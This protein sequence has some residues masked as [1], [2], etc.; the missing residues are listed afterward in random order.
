L[1]AEATASTET[2]VRASSRVTQV[3][4]HDSKFSWSR[5]GHFLTPDTYPRACF[6]FLTRAVRIARV[7]PA[8]R[9]SRRLGSSG[10]RFS[11]RLAAT[12]LLYRHRRS[13]HKPQGA[14]CA[15]IMR[16]AIRKLALTRQRQ[17]RADLPSTGRIS[18]CALV[19]CASAPARRI[20]EARSFL[21]EI[22]NPIRETDC[23]RPLQ[24]AD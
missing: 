19:T 16:A 10:Y 21:H 24:R 14:A 9:F 20:A 11:R 13:H 4:R 6:H 23:T 15:G 22:F 8:E 18:M 5:S 7:D 2:I 3:Q 1:P 17:A 12:R